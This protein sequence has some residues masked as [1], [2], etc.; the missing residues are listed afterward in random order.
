MKILLLAIVA[1]A[2]MGAAPV[3]WTRMVTRAP[4][5]AYV[6]GNPKAKVR[7]VEYLSYSCSHC[8]HFTQESAGPLKTMFVSRGTVAVEMRNAVRDRYD[9]VAAVLARCGGGAHFFAQSEALFAGQA[10]LLT[11]AQAFEASNSVP[12]DAPVND[13][14][15]GVAKGSGLTAYM[16]AH[17][18]SAT[19]Q[20]ACLTDKAAQDVV[21][22]MTKEAWE[23]R[24]IKFTPTFLINGRDVGP[25]DWSSLQPRLRAAIT[26]R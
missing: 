20:T 14:L 13:V 3:N 5:G 2:G 12:V 9:F 26:T 17:G 16:T 23:T 7:L 6:M 11:Q 19:A 8:A 21:L 24:K 25:A 15:T 4:N 18:L 22:A 10:L 1:L